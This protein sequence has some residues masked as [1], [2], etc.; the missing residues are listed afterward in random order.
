[1]SLKLSIYPNKTIVRAYSLILIALY[2]C[3]V[4]VEAPYVL[5][6]SKSSANRTHKAPPQTRIISTVILIGQHR[7]ESAPPQAQAGR[8]V[9]LP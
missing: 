4:N 1:M 6:L 5:K 9:D 3:N 8:K 7:S 2:Y